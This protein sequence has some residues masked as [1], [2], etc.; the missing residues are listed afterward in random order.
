MSRQVP[1]TER[2]APTFQ[3]PES[4]AQH[5]MSSNHARQ[6]MHRYAKIRLH[7]V[8]GQLQ[9]LQQEKD[10]DEFARQVDAA[11]DD[12]EQLLDDLDEVTA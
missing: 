5:N 4:G 7:R 11:R 10:L 2:R 8:T 9:G 12:L 1:M 3:R 6:Q